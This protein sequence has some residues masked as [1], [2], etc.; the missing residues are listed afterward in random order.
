[1]IGVWDFLGA[2][3]ALPHQG[4]AWRAADGCRSFEPHLVHEWISLENTRYQ[5]NPADSFKFNP[6][7]LECVEPA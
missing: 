3:N 4:M 5:R 2:L 6:L 1:M 7:V